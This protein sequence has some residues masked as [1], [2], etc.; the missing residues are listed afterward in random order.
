MYMVYWTEVRAVTEEGASDVMIPF[1][2]KFASSDLTAAMSFMEQLRARRR[3]GEPICFVAM[4][5]EHPDAIGPAGVAEPASDYNWK[6]R[7]R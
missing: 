6:K 5:S 4:S 2:Q 1:A 3:A 7:R